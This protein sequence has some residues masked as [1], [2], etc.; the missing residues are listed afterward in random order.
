M[1]LGRPGFETGRKNTNS[2]RPFCP[3]QWHGDLRKVA[4][5]ISLERDYWRRI[6][7]GKKCRVFMPSEWNFILP[8]L[9]VILC[10]RLEHVPGKQCTQAL[11]SESNH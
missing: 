5:K 8:N 11:C 1:A 10:H 3:S 6:L 7:R 4:V 2:K 9:A